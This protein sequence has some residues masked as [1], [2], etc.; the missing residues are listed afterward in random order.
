MSK[1]LA[2]AKPVTTRSGGFWSYRSTPAKTTTYQVRSASK[3]SRAL[4]VG[5][6]PRVTIDELGNGRIWPRVD[7]A[8][9][10]HG[11]EIALQR[12]LPNGTWQTILKQN[13]VP[14]SAAT[15]TTTLRSATV[16]TSISVNQAG[17]GYLG[18]AS[19]AMLY[20]A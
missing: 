18:T 20:H 3:L 15:L 8:R 1:S 7:G 11:N 13:L 2:S 17:L 19:H 6:Q 14:N 4:T 5:V 10:F 12:R 9:T 16:R